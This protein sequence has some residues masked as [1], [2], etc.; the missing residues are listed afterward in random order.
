MPFL[1]YAKVV[2]RNATV[3]NGQWLMRNKQICFY[4][5][6]LKKTRQLEKRKLEIAFSHQ[7]VHDSEMLRYVMVVLVL[8]RGTLERNL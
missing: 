6:N 2:T 3:V 5:T 4:H 8:T 7:K 1:F